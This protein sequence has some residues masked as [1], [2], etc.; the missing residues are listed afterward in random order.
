MPSKIAPSFAFEGAAPNQPYNRTMASTKLL[1][2]IELA[3]RLERTEA[4][5]CASFVEAHARI[6]PDCGATWQE[7]AGAHAMFDGASSPITQ[8]FRLGVFEEANDATLGEIEEFFRSRGADVFLEVCPLAGA[9]LAGRLVSRGYKP[10]ELS[11]VMF[12]E[13]DRFA[14]D[15]SSTIEVRQTGDADA[16][17]WIDTTVRG[18]GDI[19]EAADYLRQTGPVLTQYATN[20]LAEKDGSPVAAAALIISDDV[21]LLAGACTIPEARRQGA[22]LALNNARLAYAAEQGCNV[23]MV[24]AEPGSASQRNAERRGFRVAYTRTKWALTA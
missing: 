23:A 10:V 11:N 18:W 1:A 7:F 6:D 8:S 14:P 12:R 20:F 2:D 15:S 13:I 4:Y 17:S 16:D 24:V 21:A 22:Q 19:P 9:E 3:K 5:G